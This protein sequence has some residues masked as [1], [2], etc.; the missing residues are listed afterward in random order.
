M[1][2]YTSFRWHQKLGELRLKGSG[3]KTKTKDALGN[4]KR[5]LSCHHENAGDFVH[6]L[7]KKLRTT[8]LL[9]SHILSKAMIV[10]V[11][12]LVG[13]SDSS[14]F[15]AAKD[16]TDHVQHEVKG[17]AVAD[18]TG[19]TNV[20]TE[21]QVASAVDVLPE[22]QTAPTQIPVTSAGSLVK[23]NIIQ[24]SPTKKIRSGIVSYTVQNGDTMIS[25]A[26]NFGISV[27]TVRWANGIGDVDKI[28]PGAALTIL[29]L[30]GVLHTVGA[31]DT[32]EKIAGK[33]NVSSTSILEENNLNSDTLQAGQKLLVPDGSIPEPP[34]P[35]PAPAP[36][37][38]P[39]SNGKG[40]QVAAANGPI[41]VKA[42]KGGGNH[43]FPFG[44]CTYWVAQKRNIPWGGNAKEW[45]YRAK[46]MGYA[47]GKTP[48][49][50][51]VYVESWLTG[52]GHVSYVT[53][54][55]G[56]SF[57]VTEMNYAG[58]G[59]VTSRTISGGGGV[60]IY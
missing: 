7:I 23:P 19:G 26:K 54:V 25:I 40:K 50:G 51:A 44:Y 10:L 41:V 17:V 27:N 20:G 39:A 1:R 8:F 45:P 31:G 49:V 6:N 9:P 15:S 55:N 2:D 5:R 56:S 52:W 32:L 43:R 21:N 13:F 58:F 60:F 46:A 3:I 18:S 47:T 14:A 38:Q 53:S 42:G 33:Y 59:R 57:S 36:K 12:F 4:L 35:A 34:K 37:P 30:N 24:V 28:K 11:V 22:P 48:A 29:P 16:E